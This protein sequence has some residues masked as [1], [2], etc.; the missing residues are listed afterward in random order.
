MTHNRLPIAILSVFFII[1]VISVTKLFM[2]SFETGDV[3][4]AYSSLRSDPLGTRGFYESLEN[5]G[6]LSLTRNF[7]PLSKMRSS[8]GTTVFC[9]GM[10]VNEMISMNKMEVEIFERLATDGGRLIFSF[11]PVR[12]KRSLETGEEYFSALSKRWGIYVARRLEYDLDRMKNAERVLP[13]KK[14]PSS[15]LWHTR[16]SFDDD[17]SW[18]TI[19]ERDNYSVMTE[20]QF[21][22]GSIV[23]SSDSYFFSNEALKKECHPEL[24]AW[25]IGENTRL[26]FDE[27]HLG[28]QEKTGIVG[29]FRKYHLHGFFL[30]I[31]VLTGLFVWKSSAHFVPPYEDY[32]LA[33]G[34][35]FTSEKNYTEGLISLLRQ[36]IPQR[37]ILG[38]CVKE[39]EKDQEIP[40]DKSEQIKAL[41]GADTVKGY[42]TICQILLEKSGKRSSG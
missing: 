18:K 26:V 10:C 37:D 11:L 5:L 22:R 40:D 33:E 38:V 7:R 12:G 36:N 14:L 25:L 31:A 3:Y 2:L 13:E 20:K 17:A 29:L 41:S 34:H 8:Q 19:Y 9:L 16:L 4:P 24:L 32:P 21:G 39:W 28:I 6:N 27:S 23:F 1:F 30:G 35:D 42:Q 15:V